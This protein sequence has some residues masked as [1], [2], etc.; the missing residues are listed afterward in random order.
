MMETDRVKVMVR[1]TLFPALSETLMVMVCGPVRAAKCAAVL[2]TNLTAKMHSSNRTA[3][4]RR[5]ILR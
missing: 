3:R 5:A 1:V 2:N 4:S